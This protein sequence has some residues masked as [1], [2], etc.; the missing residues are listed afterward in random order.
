MPLHPDF[1]AV[2]WRGTTCAKGQ[3]TG[4]SFN[5]PD[6]AVIRLKL[7]DACARH[8]AESILE[9]LDRTNS[10]SEMS[11]GTNPSVSPQDGV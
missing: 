8:L 9:F 10:Q 2:T 1:K 11:S 7:Q 3:P 4:I 5:S 6:G